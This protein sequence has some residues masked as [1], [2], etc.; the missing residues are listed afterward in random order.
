MSE[1]EK[2]KRGR[3]RTG[4]VYPHNDHFDV[5][6][7]LPDG[8]RGNARCLPPTVSEARAREIAAAMMERG[9][10][11]AAAELLEAAKA[12]GPAPETWAGWVVRY[13]EER[14][15]RGKGTREPRGHFG[16]WVPAEMKTKPMERIDR[17]DVESIVELLDQAVADAV[18]SWKTA[19]NVWGSITKMFA[20]AVNAKTRALRVRTSNP[21]DGVEGP[22]RGA[23]K[24]KVYLYPAE[25]S[26]L[27]RCE[28]IPI[29]WRRLFALAVY[30]YQRPGELEATSIGDVDLVHRVLQVHV[31]VD[32]ESEAGE[33]KTTKTKRSRRIPI[34]PSVVPL[35]DVVIA[36]ARARG[37]QV[38]FAMPPV[39]DLS[40]RLRQYLLWAGV[41]RAE[42]HVGAD[43]PTR[44]QMTY[45]DL[46]ATG[47]TWM[48]LR[49][50]EPLRIMA[51][52]GHTSLTTTMGYVREAE[53][54]VHSIGPG[55]V[56]PTL[57]AEIFSPN[58]LPEGPA[59]WANLRDSQWNG[60]V[61][62][63]IRTR[64]QGSEVEDS[65]GF[66]VPSAPEPD[67]SDAPNYANPRDRTIFPDDIP[68]PH[69]LAEASE[70]VGEARAAED[71]LVGLLGDGVALAVTRAGDGEAFEPMAELLERGAE[72]VPRMAAGAER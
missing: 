19:V 64:S 37:E 52:A 72:L 23:K 48:A 2:R 27:M 59:T 4:A 63:G 20:D 22:D 56:F 34:E 55:D 16:T 32:R 9:A 51:R 31:A 44:K 54:L 40:S 41:D 17:I 5:R 62:S 30:L 21:C 50:D 70:R 46:R 42:L 25:F 45:Y 61:P 69:G 7:M 24:A 26:A 3:P 28:R 12:A 39:C 68:R 11:L 6:V 58:V 13:L 71:A 38:L 66:G 33:L 67:V 43:D 65:R 10:E 47:I 18:I 53:N 36:D 29:R 14:A 35:L 60:S 8:T 57:P 1:P 15:R 49:G